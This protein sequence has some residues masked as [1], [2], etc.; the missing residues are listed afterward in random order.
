MSDLTPLAQLGEFGLIRRLQHGITLTQPSTVL[1]IGDDAAI[2]APAAGHEVVV[3]TDLLVEGVHFDLSF[4]PLKHL[5]FKAVA[6]NV[7]DVAAMMATPTQLVVG[8]S[9]PSRFTVEAVEELYAGM[10]AGLR[11]LRRRPGGR[12]HHQQPRRSGYQHHGAGSWWRPARPC[13]AAGGK[14]T[15][16]HLRIG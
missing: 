12:R 11:S 8:L 6:I 7:S 5:G 4:S 14:P 16:I 15:D 9:L 1:G 10:R 3:T 2:L 13:A